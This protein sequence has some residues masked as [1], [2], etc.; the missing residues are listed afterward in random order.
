MTYFNKTR[1][2]S[3]LKLAIKKMRGKVNNDPIKPMDDRE[4]LYRFWRQERPEG[5]YFG[6]HQNSPRSETVIKFLEGK[7]NQES[8]FLEVGCNVGR[9]LNHLFQ[10]D[11][12]NLAGVEISEEA[13]KRMR[14]S[15]PDLE[16]TPIYIGPA[17]SVLP[18]LPSSEY[19]I[20][21][22]MAVLEHIHPSAISV[23]A[24]IAR[25]SNHYVLAIEPTTKKHSSHRQYPWDIRAEYEACGL[26]HIKTQPW[27]DLWQVAL[28]KENHWM[29]SMN[30]YSAM[31]FEKPVV[32]KTG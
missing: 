3:I 15:Y 1:F 22:T 13:V 14:K 24:E 32:E 30:H 10:V 17:E 7:T 16:N 12:K 31:L 2:V 28:T 25:I 6:I 18:N 26:V 20:V 29:E 9:N 21:F 5:N 8:S 23:F 4:K 11:I 19:D 27:T